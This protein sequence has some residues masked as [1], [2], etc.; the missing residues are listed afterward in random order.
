MSGSSALETTGASA[1][2]Y[3]Y[4]SNIYLNPTPI[5]QVSFSNRKS[6]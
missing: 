2:L 4:N 5:I 3:A 1:F 6:H